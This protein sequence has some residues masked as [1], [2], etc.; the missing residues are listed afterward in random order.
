VRPGADCAASADGF[1]SGQDLRTS[2]NSFQR[3]LFDH[4]WI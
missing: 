3:M 2:N 1:K 4:K